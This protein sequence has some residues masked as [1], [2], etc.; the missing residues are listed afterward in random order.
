M[1]LKNP[2]SLELIKNLRFCVFDLETTGS[3]QNFDKIIEIGLVKIE[4][5]KIVGE[6]SFLINPE[7]DIP[8]FIQKLTKIKQSDVRRAARI[9]EVI[10]EILDFMED[11]ILVAH[12]TSFDIPFFN[13]VLKRLR[14]KELDNKTICTNLM[15]RCLIPNI[16]SSNL[17]YMSKIFNI[18]HKG[19]HRALDDAKATATLLQ[20]YLKVFAN[21]GIK[22]INNLYYP[23]DNYALDRINLRYL[24]RSTNAQVTKELRSVSNKI[25]KIRSPFLVT[26]KGKNGV[27]LFSLPCRGEEME[28]EFI[29]RFIERET[30]KGVTVKLFGPFIESLIHFNKFFNELKSKTREEII[31]FLWTQHFPGQ[32]RPALNKARNKKLHN[33]DL[34]DF[35]IT[36]HLVPEQMII[37]P[38]QAM[39]LK[40]QLIFRHPGHEKMLLQYIDIKSE[41]ISKAE[42]TGKM[43]PLLEQFI[44]HYL[45][46]K[47]EQD[48][49]FIFK[50]KMPLKSPKQ[51]LKKLN[52]FMTKNP[53]PYKYP[54]RYI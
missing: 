7:M 38:L 35:L 6:K 41:R 26:I 50:K 30:F 40:N 47:A 34:G 54:Q 12:N 19:V 48:N 46:K 8:E 23:R 9:E 28:L 13:S 11:R 21:K 14:V 32:K 24:Q 42:G 51:F 4:N 45:Q 52:E 49:L 36:N 22:K 20:M 2:N 43:N 18:P 15:T 53:N 44:A 39:S 1:K 27:L 37:M 25:K 16:L 5:L 31:S 3:N 17:S 29:D 33:N 10:N